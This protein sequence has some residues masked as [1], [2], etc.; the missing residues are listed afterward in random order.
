[1]PVSS[2][3]VRHIFEDRQTALDKIKELN[4]NN[5]NPVESDDYGPISGCQYDLWERTINS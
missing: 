2:Y 3:T 4:D 5:P 1:M